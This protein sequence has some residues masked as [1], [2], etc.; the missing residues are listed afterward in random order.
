[1][2]L[3]LNTEASEKKRVL[4][5]GG[6]APVTLD[7]VRSFFEVG[8]VV[9]VADSFNHYLARS[10]NKVEKS[11]KIGSPVDSHEQFIRDLQQIIKEYQIDLLI[12]TCEEVF[13]VAKGKAILEK[14]C[15]VFCE[16]LS[17]LQ[18]LHHKYD[19]IQEVKAKGL[20]VPQTYL[21]QAED[22]YKNALDQLNCDAV[23]KPV[24]SRFGTRVEFLK[25]SDV[26][27]KKGYFRDG[28]YV[29]QE[30]IKG[31]IICNYSIFYEGELKASANYQVNYTAGKGAAIQFI[32]TPHPG[33]KK[34]L[35]KYF[36]HSKV[37]G[38]FAFDFIETESGEI[39][40][41]ECNPRATSGVHLFQHVNI[42]DSFLGLNKE[43]LE[44]LFETKRMIGLAMLVYGIRSGR[45]ID[46]LKTYFGSKDVIWSIKDMKPFF[47]QFYTYFQIIRKSRKLNISAMEASTVDIEWNGD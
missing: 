2:G 32:H 24:Y 46:F 42:A 29:L 28:L 45:F 47:Y 19:F 41:I 6:R 21:V 3:F 26:K 27:D 16:D 12:P 11:F 1:V 44:P 4:F 34:W 33:I 31:K 43:T 15:V 10:S 40:V 39:Y 17:V 37:T 25:H 9:Y 23:I 13:H 8:H 20:S 7:L 14:D 5:T 22:E 30:E 36:R 38:Q 18:Q 35:E